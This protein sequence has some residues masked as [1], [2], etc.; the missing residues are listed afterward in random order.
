[1]STGSIKLDILLSKIKADAISGFN[2]AVSEIQKAYPS[3][4]RNEAEEIHKLIS[5]SF[6]SKEDSYSL[7]VTAPPSFALKTK[8]TKVVVKEMIENAKS[9]ITM[10]GYSLSDYF[11]D[12]IDCII[13]KSQQG[14]YVKIYVNNIDDQ[15]NFDK[16]K[17]YSGRFLKLYNFVNENDKMAALHAK[18]ICIDK[19]VTL[20]TS[21][22]LSYHGQEGNIELGTQIVSKSTALQV[23]DIFTKLLYKKIFKEI[24]N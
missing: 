10:T 11:D 19:E 17:R 18:V 21:A 12:L 1:M 16:F 13:R 15:K 9:S 6:I 3:L 23:E 2:D 7:V 24:K 5:Q 14:V 8:T 22:N 20:I 4:S